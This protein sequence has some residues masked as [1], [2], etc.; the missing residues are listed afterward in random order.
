VVMPSKTDLYF[1]AEDSRSEVAM[2][3]NAELC[4]ISTIWGH[5]V[6]NLVQNPA[7]AH[8]VDEA[9]RRLLES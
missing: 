3:P 5:R 2:M 9:L 1:T 4:P 8:F 7:D 6:N